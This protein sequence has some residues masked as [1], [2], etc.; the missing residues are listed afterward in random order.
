MGSRRRR[1]KPVGE[2]AL[3]LAALD[4]LTKFLRFLGQELL[5]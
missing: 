2:A 1:E 3:A 5:S 4:P